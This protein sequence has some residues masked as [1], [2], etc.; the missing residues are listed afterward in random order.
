M[1][2]IQKYFVPPCAR[3]VST[4]GWL[5]ETRINIEVNPYK[6]VGEDG[7]AGPT[8]SCVATPTWFSFD[9]VSGNFAPQIV[10]VNGPWGVPLV[11]SEVP[12]YIPENPK[13]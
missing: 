6:D 8:P 1:A 13:R 9:G 4:N 2:A 5:N 11:T 3:L 12:N 10:E 7:V